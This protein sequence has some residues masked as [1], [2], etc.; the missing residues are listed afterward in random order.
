M[1]CNTL[2][3]FLVFIAGLFFFFSLNLKSC[4]TRLSQFPPD[5]LLASFRSREICRFRP[6]QGAPERWS[7]EEITCLQV[8]IQ[9]YQEIYCKTLTQV[10]GADES[11]FHGASRSW[12]RGS[13]A[14]FLL[15]RKA[16]VS[17][18]RPSTDCMRPAQTWSWIYCIYRVPAQ[19]TQVTFHGVTRGCGL[20]RGT[21]SHQD[22]SRLTRCP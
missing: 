12:P 10:C 7:L 1:L 6:R 20:A 11:E 5:S 14:S 3:F 21:P 18:L 15:I 19:H 22:Q 17:L 9:R 2:V 8:Q 4:H 16:S 13:W